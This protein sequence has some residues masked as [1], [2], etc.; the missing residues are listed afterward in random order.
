MTTTKTRMAAAAARACSAALA[1]LLALFCEGTCL[2]AAVSS[3]ARSR[4]SGMGRAPVRSTCNYANCTRRVAPRRRPR[5]RRCFRWLRP[6]RSVAPWCRHRRPSRALV[7]NVALVYAAAARSG[8]ARAL[9]AAAREAR[10]V[11]RISVCDAGGHLYWH[12]PFASHTTLLSGVLVPAALTLARTEP[13]PHDEL[14]ISLIA[15]LSA[16]DTA[17]GPPFVLDGGLA[18]PSADAPPYQLFDDASCCSG[19]AA[20]AAAAAGC[21]RRRVRARAS[22][23]GRRRRADGRG[24]GDG[25]ARRF[26]LALRA[27][28]ATTSAK[29]SPSPPSS[30]SR[31]CRG[32]GARRARPLPTTVRSPTVMTTLTEAALQAYLNHCSSE[33]ASVVVARSSSTFE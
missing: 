24:G 17:A 26:A 22:R 11:L 6:S 20:A 8:D 5:T 16:A 30:A 12:L 18:F 15:L 32:G 2:P 23:A 27:D 13:S 4:S 25:G 7:E 10:A 21:P 33:A 31:S 14:A 28:V 9:A 3:A 19:M 29:P 1:A